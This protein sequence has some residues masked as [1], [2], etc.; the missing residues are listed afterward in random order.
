MILASLLPTACYGSCP[1]INI[2][3][4][5]WRVRLGHLEDPSNEFPS[6]LEQEWQIYAEGWGR[7]FSIVIWARFWVCSINGLMWLTLPP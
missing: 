7:K 5:M 6:Q 4:V 3:H 2:G 1:N